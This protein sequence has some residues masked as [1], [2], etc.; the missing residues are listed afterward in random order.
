MLKTK[1]G[2]RLF[3]L[4]L[5]LAAVFALASCTGVDPS[6]DAIA[7]ATANAEEIHTQLIWD[8][9]AMSQITSNVKG[10]ITKTKFENVTVS[11][12]SSEPDVLDNT[13]K[14]TLPNFDDERAIVVE[15]ATEDKPAAKAVPVII[16][17]TITARA[18][19][20]IS[21]KTYYKEI[22]L[23]KEFKFTVATIAEGTQAGT[24]ADIKAAAATYIYD[25][26]G[27][28][29]ELVSN[30]SVVYSAM[31][32]G[33][34]TAMLNANG[35]GQFMIHDGTEGI[36]VYKTLD[37]LKV[38]DR[39]SVVGEIYSYYGALQFG[40]NISVTVIEE[41]AGL[42][43]EYRKTT[44]QELET[45]GAARN[46]KGL[47][48]AGY[49]GGELVNVYGKLVKEAAPGGSSDQY[50]VAD[51]K[52]GEKL[53][54]Y[55]KSYNEEMEAK[56]QEYVGKYVNIQGVTYDRDSRMQKNEILWDGNIEEAEAPTL[57]DADKVAIALAAVVVPAQA[58]ADFEVAL[59]EGY[60]WEVVSG[61]AIAF[62]G[63]VAKVTRGGQDEV[64]TIRLTVTVGEASDSK[65]FEVAVPA[66]KLN[67][68]SIA[69]AI[70]LAGTDGNYTADKYYIQGV[71]TEVAN[72]TY[73]NVYVEDATGKL[74][75]YGMYSADGAVRY[76]KLEG[77][78]QVG[79]LVTLYGSLGSY[80]GT[81]QMKNSWLAEYYDVVTLPEAVE[82]AGTDGSY[83]EKAYTIQGVVTE[84]ANDKYGNLYVSDGTNSFYVYGIYDYKGNKYSA[85]EYKPQV[86]DHITLTGSLGSYKGTP[87]MKNATLVE[88]VSPL[89]TAGL[90]ANA[91]AR[92]DNDYTDTLYYAKG[93]V[94]E[95]A[96]TKYG[97][98]YIQDESGT[99]YVY[100]LYS[101]DGS[102]RFDAMEAQPQVGDTVVIRGHLGNYKGTAQL[103]NAQLIVL[104]AGSGEAPHEHEFVDGKCEC[105]EVD[106]NYTPDTPEQP[107]QALTVTFDD[108]AK[109]TS[110]DGSHQ[111]WQENGVTLLVEQNTST[112]AINEKYFNP[113]RVYKNHKFTVSAEQEFSVVKY[114]IY[115]SN[116]VT[117][118]VDAFAKITLPEG[119]TLVMEENVATITLAAPTKS[120]A[121]VADSA[122]V[123]LVSATVVVGGSAP[124]QPEVPAHE[125]KACPECG[126]CV[127]EDC[128]GEAAEKC[129]GH[130]VVEGPKEYT[131]AEAA[132]LAAGTNVIL[133]GTIAR[134]DG[135]WDT[136]YENMNV[137]LK[138]ETGTFYLFRLSTQ[139]QLGDI[140]TV[141][142]VIGVYNEANQLAQGGTAVVTGHDSSYDKPVV[143]GVAT[144]KFNDKA[145]RT[146]F[147]T[148]HQVW[149]QNGIKVTNNKAASTSN[150]ADYANPARFYASSELVIEYTA[151]IEK[152]VINTADGRN[153]ASSLTI[154]GC[155][156]TVDGSV[157]TI[158]LNAPATSVTIAK[159][160]AQVRVSSIEVY[161]AK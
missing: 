121:L 5:V 68:I 39:V 6:Q 160:A 159:L 73:G 142:G 41:A 140:V 59:E 10:F 83:T 91:V 150:V 54:I 79:D 139:V 144:I 141:T 124:E 107:E 56:L 70:A 49:Y 93:V 18:E 130:E 65:E 98:I 74:Y 61:A 64:V 31:V 78:P 12:E 100:G 145:A 82:L 138:D 89:S 114:T 120:F 87:Q 53:W 134:I 103:K 113:L 80:K 23:T 9:T 17:A 101:A 88:T 75:V 112:S 115:L 71:V 148:N 110:I 48:K 52:T 81:P 51:A 105:G 127:A 44:P 45:E 33:V 131:C 8:K 85:M 37:G 97:N 156:V 118:Y 50:H 13:G 95:I 77:Q 25:E 66:A 86:G 11:W 108:T 106:P 119:A 99:I 155:T 30:S 129:P 161:P 7:Q 84:I 117:T 128:D 147:D 32:E 111:T 136:K 2:K 34:V 62:E 3:S 46:D 1:F 36:Y 152:V 135:E 153:F 92:E 151:N 90:T 19:W 42:D 102:V 125:H 57:T 14:V 122:Q 58:D 126:K 132:T 133:K 35:A 158:V 43:A 16:T 26:Q 47:V 63:N 137:T 72:S 76:D 28:Q 21:G 94:T 67:I 146:E 96:N 40:S 104:T 109:R 20:E 4:L 22:E 157:C 143:E 15:E 123:R 149:E 29:R 24:I 60:V 55:Y 38:G 116:G 27:V 69:E 154:D